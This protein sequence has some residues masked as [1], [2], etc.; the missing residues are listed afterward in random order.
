MFSD[1]PDLSRPA[2][3][4]LFSGIYSLCVVVEVRVEQ[5]TDT[6]TA[7]CVQHVSRLTRAPVAALSVQT[8]SMFTHPRNQTL[9]DI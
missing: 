6:L 1:I 3:K 5:L 2:P 9:V 4:L 8:L 7:C